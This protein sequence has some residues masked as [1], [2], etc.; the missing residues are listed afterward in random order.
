MA[1]QS[2]ASLERFFSDMRAKLVV[3]FNLEELRLLCVDLGVDFENIAGAT[4]L[5]VVGVGISRSYSDSS[6]LAP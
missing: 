1:S 3:S 4:H 5:G 2:V 6:V